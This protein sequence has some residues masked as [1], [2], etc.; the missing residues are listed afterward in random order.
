MFSNCQ[1]LLV[2]GGPFLEDICQEEIV[3][4][5]NEF[6]I[7]RMYVFYLLFSTNCSHIK[8]TFKILLVNKSPY[9]FLV[10]V[11]ITLHFLS[12]YIY[13]LHRFFVYK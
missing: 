5:P 6:G 4:E 10:L 13:D 12:I 3:P 1:R 11:K 8:N 9:S 7:L 2:I